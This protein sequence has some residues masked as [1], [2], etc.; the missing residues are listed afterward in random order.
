MA[1]Q[2]I[3]VLLGFS[4][5]TSQARGQLRELKNSLDSIVRTTQ[6]TNE[7]GITGDLRKAAQAAA[8]LN[9]HL[10]VATNMKTGTLD[11]GKLNRSIKESGTTL[12]QYA[13]KLISLGPAGQ[14]AFQQLAVAVANSEIPLKRANVLIDG[15]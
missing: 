4:A 15:L 12:Q 1:S 5:D 7:L 8:E 2:R 10:S 11:F 13:D 9:A 14:G 6:Q 3:P